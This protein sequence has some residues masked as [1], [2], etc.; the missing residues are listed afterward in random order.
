MMSSFLKYHD[1]ATTTYTLDMMQAE[2]AVDRSHA[3]VVNIGSYS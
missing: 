3:G 2:V 1:Y